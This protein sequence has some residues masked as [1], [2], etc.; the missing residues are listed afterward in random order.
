[1]IPETPGLVYPGRT[2]Q[3]NADPDDSWDPGACLSRDNMTGECRLWWFLRPRGLFIQGEHG[4]GMPTLMIPETLGLVYPGMGWQGN[5]D[6]DDS[7]D[8]GACLSR[9]NMT[10]QCQLWW[11][12]RPWGLFIQGEHGR[13]MPTLMIPETPGLV[14]P[15]ITWQG[16]DDPDDSWDPGACLSRDNMPGEWWPWWFLRPWGLFIQG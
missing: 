6:S 16:N 13:G 10:G 7:W 2:W 5:A 14:Y 1:M 15:G 11:F 9:D 8:P 12:L 3:G 4:R